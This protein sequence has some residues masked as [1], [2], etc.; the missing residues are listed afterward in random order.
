MNF[1]VTM[2]TRLE[3]FRK[4]KLSQFQ[5]NS[6]VM[7]HFYKIILAQNITKHS[8]SDEERQISIHDIHLNVFWNYFWKR[9]ES[10]KINILHHVHTE[11]QFLFS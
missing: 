7:R 6:F 11:E 10:F 1:Y 9:E 4:K 3:Y 5:E 8:K 2:C